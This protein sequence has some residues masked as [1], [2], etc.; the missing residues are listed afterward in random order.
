MIKSLSV[1]VLGLAVFI[2]GCSDDNSESAPYYVNFTYGGTDYSY[3][4]SFNEVPDGNAAA[5]NDATDTSVYGIETAIPFA[6]AASPPNA[7]YIHDITLIDLTGSD[8]S[9]AV[10]YDDTGV[11]EDTET[12]N[13]TI[14]TY[15]AEGEVIEGTFEGTKFTNGTF[16]VYNTGEE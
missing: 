14:T 8:P 16:K 1:I 9:R 3:T 11:Q 6:D 4:K 2:A 7:L 10:L 12:V 13:V 5:S 15:G